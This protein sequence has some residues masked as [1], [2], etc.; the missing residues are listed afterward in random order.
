MKH[1]SLRRMLINSGVIS[2]TL[3]V[4]SVSAQESDSTI[5]AFNN[6]DNAILR[7][8]M[9]VQELAKDSAQETFS[10]A[11][12][13]VSKSN[14]DALILEALSDKSPT[15]VEKAIQLAAGNNSPVIINKLFAIYDSALENY[16]GYDERLQ[17]AVLTSLASSNDARVAPLYKEIIA[18]DLSSSILNVVLSACTENSDSTLTLAVEEYITKAEAALVSVKESGANSLIWSDLS[19]TLNLAKEVRSA[20]NGGIK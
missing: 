14:N 10:M 13:A 6:V 5:M 17:S 3:F 12:S 7:K 18:R 20:Q 19:Q 11:R 8:Q 9:L 1:R 16:L 2:S 4:L 15:V